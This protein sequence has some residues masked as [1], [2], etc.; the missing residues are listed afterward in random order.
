MGWLPIA[1]STSRCDNSRQDHTETACRW[2]IARMAI[3]RDPHISSGPA[4]IMAFASLAADKVTGCLST[5]S[6]I[7]CAAGALLRSEPENHCFAVTHEK[8]A[9]ADARIF[10]EEQFARARIRNFCRRAALMLKTR[11]A[12][13]HS[14][15]CAGCTRAGG[16]GRAPSCNSRV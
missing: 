14:R 12:M 16:A 3:H 9:P 1:L 5:S 15:C 6:A 7:S 2:P 10:Q 8:C 4:Q 13:Q 11:Q